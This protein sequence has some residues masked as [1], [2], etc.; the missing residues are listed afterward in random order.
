MLQQNR[1]ST[2]VLESWRVSTAVEGSACEVLPVAE[3]IVAFLADRRT[4]IVE[5]RS[6]I[7]DD[8]WTQLRV[9]HVKKADS[10]ADNHYLFVKGFYC[11]CYSSYP[12]CCV[13]DLSLL[14][15]ARPASTGSNVNPLRTA[16]RDFSVLLA[17]W[18]KD[19]GVNT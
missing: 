15:P 16:N 12:L 5:R 9:G 4:S 6:S 3:F 10:V 18:F 2:P 11:Y 17:N 7:V 13:L 8:A 14:V 1:E 19:H